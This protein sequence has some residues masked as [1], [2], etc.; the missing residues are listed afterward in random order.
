MNRFF[1]YLKSLKKVSVN[2][3]DNTI[4]VGLE[5]Y[6]LFAVLWLEQLEIKVE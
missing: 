4:I 1:L 6:I 3:T 2:E 5:G